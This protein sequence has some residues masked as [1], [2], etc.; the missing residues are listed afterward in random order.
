[1]VEDPSSSR[2]TREEVVEQI[3]PEASPFGR[4]VDMDGD[5][6]N[7]GEFS[8]PEESDDPSIT[9]SKIRIH[10]GPLYNTGFILANHK[11]LEKVGPDPNHLSSVMPFPRYTFVI[12]DDEL[13][14]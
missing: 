6:N 11:W 10:L 14:A 8:S 5:D 1:M 12:P 9:S 3:N 2:N 4:D 7:E 13:H